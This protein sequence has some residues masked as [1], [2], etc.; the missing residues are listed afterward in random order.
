MNAL[1]RAVLAREVLRGGRVSRK[2]LLITSACANCSSGGC[3]IIVVV[4][5]VLRCFIFCF[6]CNFVLCCELRSS[7]LLFE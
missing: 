4:V 5:V 7:L 3:V 1:Q 6:C 2:T